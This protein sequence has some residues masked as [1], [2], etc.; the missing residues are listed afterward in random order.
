LRN[1]R[2][3]LEIHE[4]TGTLPTEH[5]LIAVAIQI[6]ERRRAVGPQSEGVEWVITA[7]LLGDFNRIGRRLNRQ[8]RGV[9]VQQEHGG[10]GRHG[11]RVQHSFQVAGTVLAPADD[12]LEAFVAACPVRYRM[13]QQCFFGLFEQFALAKT[14]WGW[15]QPIGPLR[16]RPDGEVRIMNYKL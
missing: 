9:H 12:P 11:G 5:I 7:G 6:Y 15:G 3:I 8:R 10:G 14:G 13:G 4:G 16:L 1:G 2:R